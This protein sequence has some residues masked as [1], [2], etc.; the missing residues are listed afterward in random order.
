ML[1]TS[2]YGFPKTGEV[3]E[4]VHEVEANYKV[5]CYVKG[6]QVLVRGREARIPKKVTL[7]RKP[8]EESPIVIEVQRDSYYSQP[9]T[10]WNVLDGVTLQ[11]VPYVTA[12]LKDGN[13]YG[14]TLHCYKDNGVLEVSL[15]NQGMIHIDVFYDGI[16]A[17]SKEFSP[18]DERIEYA[19]QYNSRDTVVRSVPMLLLHDYN[20]VWK[21]PKEQ[22]WFAYFERS[23]APDMAGLKNAFKK[24][25][26]MLEKMRVE[27]RGAY[28]TLLWLSDSATRDGTSNNK[29]ICNALEVAGYEELVTSIKSMLSVFKQTDQES[30][31]AWREL[32]NPLYHSTYYAERIHETYSRNM[33]M[34]LPGAQEKKTEEL[35]KKDWTLR[36]TNEAKA[37]GLGINDY[38]LL[39][40]E[41]ING[42]IP[43]SIFHNPDKTPVNLEFEIWEKALARGGWAPI[44]SKIALDAGR[45]TTY[46]KDVTPYLA[47]LFQL[48]EYLEK[49]TGQ[50]WAAFPKYVESQ[51]EL[52]MDETNENGTAKRRSAFT[53]I[54]DNENGTVEVPYVAVSVGGARTQWCYSRHYHL[55]EEGRLDPE[56]EGIWTSDLAEKLN[57][58]D[59]YGM[60]YYTLTGTSSA[61]GY[62]T[63]LIIFERLTSLNGSNAGTTRVHF[64]RCHPCRIKDGVKVPS[65][66]H[67]QALYQ[68]MAGNIPASDIAGQQ[69]DMIYIKCEGN[70]IEN[71]A[72]VADPIVSNEITFESHRMIATEGTISL[73]NS[74]AKEPKNRLAFL[75]AEHGFRV[76]HPEHENLVDLL[77]GYY[78]IRRCKSWEA[79]PK[80]VWSYSHD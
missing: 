46:G 14:P 54:A 62:P 39:L 58:R 78:E 38:P 73:F 70:P 63:F 9:H 18:Q 64:H 29:I 55:A 33:C 36:K 56:G 69:G 67:I 25:K 74:E 21:T 42:R 34:L 77:P 8:V 53:P 75:Y 66:R 16:K 23:A 45:H 22:I 35:A 3:F 2:E 28:N 13:G 68:Y 15:T 65:H 52:E 11:R 43:F 30:Y 71:G 51:W 57:G 59:D 10:Q 32:S 12:K 50:A 40:E 76:E 31:N 61:R 4:Y 24:H 6:E 44:I 80:A 49:H 19:N 79:N 27:E 1:L 5:R 20:I 7:V 41:V 37:E 72:K 17:G 48:E 60:M 26:D 47:F